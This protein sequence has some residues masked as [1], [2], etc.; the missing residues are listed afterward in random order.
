LIFCSALTAAPSGVAVNVPVGILVE[1]DVIVLVGVVE[2]VRV[3]VEVGI[4]VCV[5][6][7]TLVA[8]KLGAISGAGESVGV[9]LVVSG[10]GILQPI[11]NTKPRKARDVLAN[12]DIALTLSIKGLLNNK[13]GWSLIHK[14]FV[15][16]DSRTVF[17]FNSTLYECD[18]KPETPG[19]NFGKDSSF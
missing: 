15:G 3:N 12:Q 2:G 10:W 14:V 16:Y 18:E 4:S 1:V 5:A 19:K 8:V 7:G 17:P 6:V 11:S 9:L 13:R